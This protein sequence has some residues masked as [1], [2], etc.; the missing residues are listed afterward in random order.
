MF[1]MAIKGY[2]I[3]SKLL[4]LVLVVYTLVLSKDTAFAQKSNDAENRATVEATAS[5]DKDEVTIGDKIKFVIRVKYKDD[6]AIQFPEI[7]EQIGVVAIKEAGIAGTPK[8]EKDGVSVV[9]RNYLLSSYEIGRHTIPSLKIKYKGSQGDGEVATNEVIIDVK[10]VIKE[11]EIS[12]DIKDILSPVDVP[13]S[14]KRLILWISIGMGAFLLSGIIY[15]LIYKFKKRS[16]IQEQRFIKRTPHEIAYELL[17]RL[18]GE[19]LVA[20]GLIR[21]YYYRITNILRHYIEDRFGLFAPERTTEEFLAEMAH[22]NKLDDTHKILFREFLERCDMVKYAKYGPSNLEIKET[23]DAAKRFIDETRERMEE[24]E[25]V[26][27][28]K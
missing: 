16:K 6:I 1:D 25:V 13:T 4:I 11:G 19:D 18:S 7:G 20:K 3:F 27:D 15:G 28:R 26:A 17:E 21:E 24:K 22:T 10:G 9:E 2:R 23:Y 8:R 12:G 14:F 5:V